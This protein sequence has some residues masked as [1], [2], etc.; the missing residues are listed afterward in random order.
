MH[1]RR[2][3]AFL[4]PATPT[5]YFYS[6]SAKGEANMTQ[7]DTN[8]FNIDD[9]SQGIARTLTDGITTRIFPG[10]QAMI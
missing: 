3:A 1:N 10:L 2:L 8:F 4:L 9:M 6:N 5:Q 7:K